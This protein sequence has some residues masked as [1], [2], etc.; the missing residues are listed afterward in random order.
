MRV[1]DTRHYLYPQLYV[2]FPHLLTRTIFSMTKPK[3]INSNAIQEL[4]D[5]MDQLRRPTTGCPWDLKQ[6]WQSLFS[7]TLEEVYEVGAAIDTGKPEALCD[8][9]GDLL[10]QIVFYSQIAKE[11][12]HFDLN[13]VAR[14]V[15]KKMIRRHP[16]VFEG[17]KYDSEADQKADWEKIKQKERELQADADMATKPS[18]HFSDILQSQPALM[19]S[20]KLKKRAAQFGFDWHEWQP[21]AEKVREELDEVIECILEKQG[22]KRIEEEVGDLLLSVAN[23]SHQLKIEPENALRKANNKF[24]RRVDRLREILEISGDGAEYNDEALDNAWQQVKAE[25]KL[26]TDAP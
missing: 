15:S 6:T 25:E 24:E 12:G 7:F 19:R 5:V 21:V 3:P 9:L 1:T 4:L 16:H 8:E 22:Q 26:K 13:T 20:V 17:K 14:T 18:G 2:H 11:Q 10:F 23:L